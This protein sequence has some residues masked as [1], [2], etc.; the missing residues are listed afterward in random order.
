MQ[1]SPPYA[2]ENE[3]EGDEFQRDRENTNV[4][5]NLNN[6]NLRTGTLWFNPPPNEG[7]DAS[8]N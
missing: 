2:E 1:F 8:N 3:G 6:P 4:D 7:N 5:Q